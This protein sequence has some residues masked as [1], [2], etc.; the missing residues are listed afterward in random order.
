MKTTTLVYG[1]CE[2]CD[3]ERNKTTINGRCKEHDPRTIEIQ[4]A[5]VRLE[6]IKG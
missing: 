4:E 2:I 5:K 3:D 6:G 1:L